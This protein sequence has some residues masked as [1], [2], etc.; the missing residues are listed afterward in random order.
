MLF[1]RPGAEF[2]LSRPP[3][4]PQLNRM[5]P[6]GTSTMAAGNDGWEQRPENVGASERHEDQDSEHES[7][8]PQSSA[9]AAPPTTPPQNEGDSPQNQ[10]DSPQPQSSAQTEAPTTP[11][12]NEGD[13]PQNEGDS[14]QPQPEPEPSAEAAPPTTPPQ[15]EGNSPQPSGRTPEVQAQEQT[16][17]TEPDPNND[18]PPAGSSDTWQ[19][20]FQF[21]IGNFFHWLFHIAF[22]S[23]VAVLAWWCTPLHRRS[24]GGSLASMESVISSIQTKKCR[25]IGSDKYHPTKSA[26]CG[27]RESISQFAKP[28]TRCHRTQNVGSSGSLG[29]RTWLPKSS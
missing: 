26:I 12:Q 19:A 27:M 28:T 9:Q 4:W 2:S 18:T 13:S 20:P 25:N 10:G 16:T 7:V 6:R 1:P 11:P 3:A 22:W 17:Q 14:P 29:S 15:N 8:Q 5:P 24:G 23:V 21:S